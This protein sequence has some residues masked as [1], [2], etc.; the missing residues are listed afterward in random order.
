V[1]LGQVTAIKHIQLVWES[2]FGKAYQ[3]QT[4]TDNTNWTTIHTTATGTG[5]VDDFDVS[6]TGRYVRMLGTA[7]GTT[8]GYSLYEFGIYA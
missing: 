7:R 3:I 4:S 1:D 5:G 8:F 6:G 2:A